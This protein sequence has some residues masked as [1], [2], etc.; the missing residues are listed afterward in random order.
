ML[1]EQS[2][3]LIELSSVVNEQQ[4]ITLQKQSVLIQQLQEDK[5]VSEYWAD[6]IITRIERPFQL[7]QNN[8]RLLYL[9]LS[10][11]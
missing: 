5:R 9:Y 8:M 7:F 1:D 4:A 11:Q 10:R 3:T 6:F 2:K